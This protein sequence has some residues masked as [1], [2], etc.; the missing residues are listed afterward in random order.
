MKT[1][2]IN[3]MSFTVLLTVSILLTACTGD[4]TGGPEWSANPETLQPQTYELTIEAVKRVDNDSLSAAMHRA[5]SVNGNVIDVTWSEGDEV[6]VYNATKGQVLDGKLTAQDG[7]NLSTTL[8]GKLTGSINVG[9]VLRFSYKSPA[10]DNQRPTLQYIADNCDYALV[11]ATVTAIDAGVLN[12]N[13]NNVEFVSQQAIVRFTF[14]ATGVYGPRVSQMKV[15]VDGKTYTTQKDESFA[16]SVLYVAIPGF[17]GRRISLLATLNGNDYKFTKENVT[18]E[19][20]KYYRI[21]VTVSPLKNVSQAAVE[22]KNKFIGTDGHIYESKDEASYFGT[23][24][25]ATIVYVGSAGA[26]D[27]S[28][29]TYKGLA[30]AL[31]G[32]S[33]STVEKWGHQ[34]EA[35][36]ISEHTKLAS[37]QTDMAGIRNTS[38]LVEVYGTKENYVARI[39]LEFRSS[40][41]HPEGTSDWFIASCGQWVLL[42]NDNGAGITT[43]NTWENAPFTLSNDFSSI[44]NFS[45]NEILWTSTEYDTERAVYIQFPGS[46][47]A[48]VFYIGKELSS[49]A[50]GTL[51]PF[52]AF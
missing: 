2:D 28:S 50:N 26:V 19:S 4:D 15:I 14:N 18:F 42:L 38:K 29:D 37:A 9:D 17:S 32:T 46:S 31:E 48:T 16:S 13:S 23:T 11:E 35:V 51:R 40:N 8:K 49:T 36:D 52:L 27:A 24:A 33:G 39:L 45:P 7:G 34:A 6:S 47:Q 43:D 25:C 3:V 21:N 20:G 44:N 30:M 1:K 5:L 22:D 10:Y 12:L 41:P